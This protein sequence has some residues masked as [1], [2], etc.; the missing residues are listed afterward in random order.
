MQNKSK[1]EADRKE[2]EKKN[3]TAAKK[4]S[5]VRPPACARC[6]CALTP[7]RCRRQAARKEADRAVVVA[8]LNAPI[9]P[10]GAKSGASTAPALFVL[11]RLSRR[12]ADNAHKQAGLGV[13][14][15]GDVGNVGNGL[16]ADNA[17]RRARG[18]RA[19]RRR[20]AVDARRPRHRAL[21]SWGRLD[22][23]LTSSPC[24]QLARG[25]AKFP[26]GARNR[27]TSIQSL[28]PH[29]STKAIIARVKL[30]QAETDARRLKEKGVIGQTDAFAATLAKANV[31]APDDDGR[32]AF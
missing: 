14:G 15:V 25:V 11:T 13:S 18:R 1:I 12:S 6:V 24:A 22:D 21:S 17:R 31:R 2:K 29:K 16:G 30:V 23:V 5:I 10:I 4:K 8:D 27:W 28:L 32:V 19:R 9:V 26:G 20:Q 7:H 3:K